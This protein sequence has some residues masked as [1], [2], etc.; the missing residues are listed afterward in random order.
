[1]VLP[2]PVASTDWV[3]AMPPMKKGAAAS[4]MKAV[5]RSSSRPPFW[6]T[7]EMRIAMVVFPLWFL[8]AIHGPRGIPV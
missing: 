1:M 8:G 6:M 2:A 5:R 7:D 4:L 3:T